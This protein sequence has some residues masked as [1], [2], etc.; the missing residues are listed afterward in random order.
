[1]KKSTYALFPSFVLIRVNIF[2][3]LSIETKPIVCEQM[4]FPWQNVFLSLEKLFFVVIRVL[5]NCFEKKKKTIETDV[6]G[7]RNENTSRVQPTKTTT[8]WN[9]FVL[10]FNSSAFVCRGL[11]F[12][13]ELSI[14]DIFHLF[15][16]FGENKIK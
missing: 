4:V 6:I 13:A 8:S 14:V 9:F 11:V 5:W 3:H 10:G 1:M 16:F 12:D 2:K 7:G 15:F